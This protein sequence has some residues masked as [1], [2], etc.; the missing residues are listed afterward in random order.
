MTWWPDDGWPLGGAPCLS[1]TVML[2]CHN[3]IT[4]LGIVARRY[5]SLSQDKLLLESRQITPL[6]VVTTTV[7]LLYMCSLLLLLA[8]LFF[9][10]LCFWLPMNEWIFQARGPHFIPVD[11]GQPSLLLVSWPRLV[12]VACWFILCRWLAG[13]SSGCGLLL[14]SGEPFSQKWCGSCKRELVALRCI[15][16]PKKEMSEHVGVGALKRAVVRL[17]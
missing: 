2:L 8:G 3:D 15:S 17:V 6:C 10:M 1:V 14:G 9:L 5:Y 13:R 4:P 11:V 16:A 12:G 7:L